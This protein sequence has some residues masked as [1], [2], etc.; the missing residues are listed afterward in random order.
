MGK[1]HFP[2]QKIEVEIRQSRKRFYL[3]ELL[4]QWRRAIIRRL[5][6]Y[7]L[8]WLSSPVQIFATT[9]QKNW[10]DDFDSLWWKSPERT[11]G[12]QKLI[13]LRFT[14]IIFKNLLGHPWFWDIIQ[15]TYVISEWL[16]IISNL[17]QANFKLGFDPYSNSILRFR[18]HVSAIVH[19]KERWQ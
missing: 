18:M 4:I 16:K 2:F 13:S 7:S 12:E 1:H 14:A 5:F 19:T 9:Q 3:W 15:R 8:N 6:N 10:T 17:N 11:Y